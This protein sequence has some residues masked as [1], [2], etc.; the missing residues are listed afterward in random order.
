MTL[1]HELLVIEP[2]RTAVE[3]V[4]TDWEHLS[5]HP[6]PV[7]TLKYLHRPERNLALSCDHASPH[8]C[9]ENRFRR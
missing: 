6:S 3:E 1:H 7:L 4:W 9:R 5:S 2:S 8:T